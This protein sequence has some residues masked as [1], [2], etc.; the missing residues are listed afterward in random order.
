MSPV[1]CCFNFLRI[2]FKLGECKCEKF[3]F[4]RDRINLDPLSA[5]A[6]TEQ[7][8]IGVFDYIISRTDL[9][10]KPVRPTVVTMS[11]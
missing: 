4:D 8:G 10:L 9:I 5:P 6:S 3:F 1:F 2:L 7:L 11:P